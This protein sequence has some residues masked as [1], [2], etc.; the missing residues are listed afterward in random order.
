MKISGIALSE[1]HRANF[2]AVRKSLTERNTPVLLCYAWDGGGP[3]HWVVVTGAGAWAGKPYLFLMCPS[4]PSTLGDDGGT[5]F[6]DT[7]RLAGPKR[8]WQT[9]DGVSVNVTS[10]L[11]VAP[12]SK[13]TREG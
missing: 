12:R 10:A 6:N 7:L 5:L 1:D 8:G 4:S 2:E 9:S 3:G 11:E 13:R